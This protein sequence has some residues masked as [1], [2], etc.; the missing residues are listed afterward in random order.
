MTTSTDSESQWYPFDTGSTIGTIGSESGTI[1]R[2]EEHPAGTRI[3]LERGGRTAPFA[4]TCGIYGC[5]YHTVFIGSESEASTTYDAMKPRLA[6]L[7]SRDGDIY[8]ELDEFT[9]QFP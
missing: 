2:D 9:K 8:D 4:I 5:F 6:E 3:T 7:A 1:I